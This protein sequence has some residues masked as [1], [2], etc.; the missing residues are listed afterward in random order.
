[1]S[2]L[3]IACTLSEEALSA[4]RE[5][6]LGRVV[7]RASTI[8]KTPAGYR[9]EF[10][11][12]PDTLSLLAAMIEAERQCCQFLRFDLRIEP[13]VGPISLELTGPEGTQ[14]FLEAL[15]E[16]PESFRKQRIQA[17]WAVADRSR[18]DLVNRR[19][20]DDAFDVGEHGIERGAG[21]ISPV[22]DHSVDMRRLR[23]VLQRVRV[24]QDEVGPFSTRDRLR[25]RERT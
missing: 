21:Q 3:P 10:T 11:A 9:L 2:E 20:P 18:I 22:G 7:R 25:G 1:M 4:R 8:T 15:L 5:G 23:D 14:A 19:A 16:T 24:E 6:L 12:E 17:Q 13:N